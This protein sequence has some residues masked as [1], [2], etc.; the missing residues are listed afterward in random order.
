MGPRR[1]S[2]L[3]LCEAAA[4]RG[5]GLKGKKRRGKRERE[6]EKRTRAREE[7]ETTRSNEDGESERWRKGERMRD[8][9]EGGGQGMEKEA[10]ERKNER[11]N[12]RTWPGH[13]TAATTE[14]INQRAHCARG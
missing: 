8:W 6:R 1:Y 3:A 10:N 7:S 11:T 4:R 13:V 12:E 5:P 9:R 14:D 2:A